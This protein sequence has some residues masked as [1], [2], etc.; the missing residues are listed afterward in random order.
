MFVCLFLTEFCHNTCDLFLTAGFP[1]RCDICLGSLKKYEELYH[2]DMHQKNGYTH[3]HINDSQSTSFSPTFHLCCFEKKTTDALPTRDLSPC[4]N[5]FCCP[6][7]NIY[8]WGTWINS[9]LDC[10]SSSLYLRQFNVVYSGKDK[11]SFFF[12]CEH[13]EGVSEV[14]CKSNQNLKEHTDW[15]P[16][17]ADCCRSYTSETYATIN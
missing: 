15:T 6:N 2:C 9:H 13:L 8:D 16:D 4:R 14:T 11:K 17:I 1:T 7:I 10:L 3:A 5:I 12:F